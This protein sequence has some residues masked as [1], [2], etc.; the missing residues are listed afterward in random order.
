M[1]SKTYFMMT[2]LHK[3]ILRMM[4]ALVVVLMQCSCTDDIGGGTGLSDASNFSI[5]LST[6]SMSTR[7]Y[8]DPVAG[9]N[10]AENRISNYYIFLYNSDD[11]APTHVISG[12]PNVV[13]G[14]HSVTSKVPLNVVDE[15]FGNGN[16]CKAYAVVNLPA[17]I[18][19]EKTDE[20][21]KIGGKVATI[22]NINA[23]VVNY[24]FM[25]TSGSVQPE[26]FVM[27]GSADVTLDRTTRTM[28]GKIDL[29]RVA[30][31]IRLYAH[32]P[33]KIYIDADGIALSEEDAKARFGANYDNTDEEA[34]FE[35]EEGIIY[36]SVPSSF[37]AFLY[38][39]VKS[40][41]IDG[42][43]METTAENEEVRWLTDEDYFSVPKGDKT[44]G[45]VM[46]SGQ[47]AD[48]A[49]SGYELTHEVPLY[50]Y[51]NKWENSAEEERQTY[52]ILSVEWK[53]SD[54]DPS[55]PDGTLLLPCYYQ[56]PINIKSTNPN[57]LESNRYYRIGLKV[58]M[59]GSFSFGDPLEIEDASWEVL[60][61]SEV[62]INANF[63]E[64]NYLVF[65]QA[66][67]VMNNEQIIEIPFTTSQ[68]VEV[69]ACYVT[70]FKFRDQWG[71][72]A[73]NSRNEFNAR[74]TAIGNANIDTYEGLV[75][76]TNNYGDVYV[77]PGYYSGSYY[78]GREHPKTVAKG[79]ETKPSSFTGTNATSY[80]TAW[81]LYEQKFGMSE[82]Y[83]CKIEGNKLIFNHPLVRWEE[84]RN[85]SNS[86]DTRP[87]QYFVPVLNSARTGF[88]DAYS[89]YEITI[90]V[91]IKGDD[92]N[93]ALQQLRQ[94]IHI[95]QY[96]AMYID[97]SHNPAGN[98]NNNVIVNGG[99]YNNSNYYAATS[100]L[101]G[102]FSINSNANPNMYVIHTTQLSEDNDN[103]YIIGDPR[104][105]QSDLYLGGSTADWTKTGWNAGGTRK[106]G[107]KMYDN[108][109]NR[110][111]NNTTTGDLRYY[112]PT[113]ESKDIGSKAK[114]IA[115]AFRI[116]S[117][118]GRMVSVSGFTKE[119]AKKRCA[120]YQEAGR[121]AGRWRLPTQAEI[122]Y[123]V[124]LSA[125]N[126][127]PC[128]FGSGETTKGYYWSANGIL[129]V[130]YSGNIDYNGNTASG[131]R[132]V[133]D[134]WYWVNND[135]TEDLAPGGE[136]CSTF[137]WGDKPK[138]NPQNRQE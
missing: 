53:T 120:S 124:Q 122:E 59:L 108:N 132:C 61:W 63:Q 11:S 50:S 126:I 16:Q 115:P 14:T 56:I 99:D 100:P 73:S 35:N 103:L 62:N 105:L 79:A 117:S 25:K 81:E 43:P 42:N 20:G 75:Q 119:N 107:R 109:G 28:T 133:Y 12:T 131:V 69:K 24:D 36:T 118:H 4:L 38:N 3:N 106:T 23:T 123:I 87:A 41:R 116:A 130:D 52:I 104:T 114:F 127:I 46:K 29:S 96:P 97:V 110:L 47:T 51:P 39:G 68:E 54:P 33:A 92:N 112:Y 32:I 57:C 31:K 72:D 128:L 137:Y 121:P 6:G 78:V 21:W 90:I 82:M 89:R 83:Q 95:T 91:G 10:D 17:S 80:R 111:T 30:S 88:K 71:T 19:V 2:H 136:T 49:M 138:D 113:D 5:V 15:L 37:V 76:E 86:L 74:R 101:N 48:N 40:A 135:G 129:G 44:N 27:K 66:S 94:T 58:G 55:S 98:T 45:R 64:G 77:W 93:P 60:D 84:K 7:A 102:N 134:D 67:F 13:T 65:N 22:S 8:G 1:N 125:E 70:Y 9:E 18:A 85:D 34:K 26:N